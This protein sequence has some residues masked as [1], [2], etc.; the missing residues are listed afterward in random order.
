[1]ALH[2]DVNAK[3]EESVLIPD[4][5][6]ECKTEVDILI[7][8]DAGGN[9]YR[10]AVECQEHRRKAGIGWI[11]QLSKK[12]ESCLLD[13]IVAV[14]SKGFSKPALKLAEK[15]GIHALTLEK[16]AEA[17]WPS[18][19]A[20]RG[21][22]IFQYSQ[23]D[24][25]PNFRGFPAPTDPNF[26][27][28]GIRIEDKRMTIDQFSEWAKQSISNGFIELTSPMKPD[29]PTIDNDFLS[30]AAWPPGKAALLSDSGESP[31][32]YVDFALRAKA[33]SVRL[34]PSD[35]LRLG[36][37]AVQH[38]KGK[39]FGESVTATVTKEEN[40]AVKL[41]V[42]M[43]NATLSKAELPI[44]PAERH[45][46]YIQLPKEKPPQAGAAVETQKGAAESGG[47]GSL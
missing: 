33:G 5:K 1:M 41:A 3:V 29:A 28:T 40:G 10:T 39:V 6:G 25:L 36:K 11:Q 2:A 8:F 21:R 26:K 32:E 18:L 13:K 23:I 42:T 37:T 47:V 38:S 15:E 14:H 12:K 35:Y 22:V 43:T 4:Y 17:D 46:I 16:V 19:I 30:R 27:V 9:K 20:I 44:P 34:E 45:K 7:S 24:I 31:L